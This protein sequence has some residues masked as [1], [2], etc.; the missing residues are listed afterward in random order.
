MVRAP[1]A[2]V[3]LGFSGA[4]SSPAPPRRPR[5]RAPPE[6]RRAA[7]GPSPLTAWRAAWIPLAPPRR[8]GRVPG[9]RPPPRPWRPLRGAPRPPA[10]RRRP[11]R[12][13]KGRW[14]RWPRP[15]PAPRSLRRSRASSA[16]PPGSPASGPRRTPVSPSGGAPRR[17]QVHVHGGDLTA[18]HHAQTHGLPGPRDGVEQGLHIARCPVVYPEQNV[19]DQQA[20]PPGG[21]AG[22][23][24]GNHEASL[25]YFG[26][27]A[28]Q[29]CGYLDRQDADPQ[30][31]TLLVRSR[32]P[33]ARGVARDRERE[34][35]EDHGVYPDDLTARV[36]ERPARVAGCQRDVGLDVARPP[37]RSAGYA[38]AAHDACGDRP[39][40]TPRVADGVGEL[41][42]TQSVRVPERGCRQIT[43]TVLHAEQREV[44][45][46]ATLHD[47]G[48]K[49]PAVA[50]DH[51]RLRAAASARDDVVVGEHETLFVPDHAG[52]DAAAPGAH[53]HDALLRAPD[54]LRARRRR[55]LRRLPGRFRSHLGLLTALADGDLQLLELAPADHLDRDLL[56]DPIAGEQHQQVLGVLDRL[57]VQ[58]REDVAY[59]EAAAPRGAAVL[60]PD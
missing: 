4:R 41:P 50:Q 20:G 25:R 42:D 40:P 56:S 23:D 60:D 54:H 22:S 35:A 33:R 43:R 28:A 5:R 57:A 39:E 6:G 29:R 30:A 17:S 18:A 44:Q 8:R 19:A 58:R 10:G 59:D 36:E 45:V 32:E 11:L 15:P 49:L 38:E 3:R 26:V 24:G 52:P 21:S 7:R 47:L 16:A 48:A 53:L 46:A 13:P 2:A 34:A 9:C 1:A 55:P 27:H 37:P 12:A 14:A 31:G 51:R